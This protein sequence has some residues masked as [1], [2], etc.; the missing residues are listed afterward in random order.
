MEKK[1]DFIQW[2]QE[3]MMVILDRDEEKARSEVPVVDADPEQGLSKKQV[4]ERT[5]GGW[6]AGDPKPAGRTGTEIVV[7]N[8]FTFFNLVFVVLVVW[9]CCSKMQRFTMRLS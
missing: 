9:W 1:K 7:I 3:T 6:A 8:L 5:E 2:L 4:K